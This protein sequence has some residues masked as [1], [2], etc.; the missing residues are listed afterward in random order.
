ML[1]EPLIDFSRETEPELAHQ[2]FDRALET[3]DRRGIARNPNV[4][5]GYIWEWRR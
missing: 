2:C 4:G 3:V 1:D 5:T